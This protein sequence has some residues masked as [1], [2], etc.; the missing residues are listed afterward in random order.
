MFDNYFMPSLVKGEYEVVAIEVPQECS[1]AFRKDDWIKVAYRK[2]ELFLKI[3]EENKGDIV[4][5]SDVDVQFF[6][7]TKEI[8][9]EELGDYDI[10]MQDDGF[11]TVCS[12]FFIFRAN[13]SVINMFKSMVDNLDKYKEDQ[14][15][16]NM[17]RKM[18]KWGFLSNKFFTV[19]HTLG[20]MWN[21]KRD[22]T[23]PEDILVHHANWCTY[24]D[25]ISLLEL[26]RY[27]KALT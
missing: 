18:V 16:L 26:V 1:G 17:N 27:K 6:G 22:I 25:K 21:T 20:R 9:I 4:L 5:F 24:R 10:K 11:N 8:L 19:F 13:D 15:A 23:V 7:R 12:G 3:A 2:V 14:T